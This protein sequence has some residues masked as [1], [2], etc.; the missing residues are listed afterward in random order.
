MALWFSFYCT[1]PKILKMK[2]FARQGLSVK[3]SLIRILIGVAIGL[4]IFAG[5][6]W[7]L[8]RTLG[9]G[10][11]R[12]QGKSRY[13]WIDQIQSQNAAASNQACLVLNQEI[14]PRLTK[15]MFEDTNDSRLRVALVENLDRLLGS[16]I[17]FR[18]SGSRRADAAAGLGEFG[19]P[20]RAAVPALF[21][22][23]Q[24]PDLAVRGPAAISLGK[25]HGNPDV[26]IP[27]LIRYLD[28]EDLKQAATEALG[29]Y[30]SPAK[31]AIPKLIL[32]SNVLDKDLRHAIAVALQKIDPEAAARN[33]SRLRD[34]SA[35]IPPTGEK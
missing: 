7:L 25:I 23:L 33:E 30:G 14:I 6:L 8:T 2:S 27:L 5:V 20:A 16:N 11:A 13:E 29:E 28:E 1:A 18:P 9:Q 26:V 32:V 21:Q 31:A 15:T 12:Y 19:P 35:S 3:S 10:I 34:G 22:A 24:G 4:G 17:P